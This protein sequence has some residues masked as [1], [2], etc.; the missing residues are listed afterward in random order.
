MKHFLILGSRIALGVY[1]PALSL[2]K[3]LEALGDQADLFCLEELY[4]GKDRVMEATKRSMHDD[5][6]LAR[7]S[8]RM[9]VRN[10]SV[11]DP[12]AE[13]AFVKNAAEKQY[14]A[15]IAFSGFFTAFLNCLCRESSHYQGRIY[16]VHMDAGVSRSWRDA[17]LSGIQEIWLYQLAGQKIH[18]SLEK[19]TEPTE[20]LPRMLVHGGGWGIGV[21]RDQIRSLNERGIPLD[22]IVYYPEEAEQIDPMNACFLLD[23]AWKPSAG[24][25]E[26][27]RLL[28]QDADGW[29]PFAD[30]RHRNPVRTLMEQDIAVLSKPGGGTLADSLCTG[31]PLIFSEAL[32]SYETEN[33]TLWEQCGFGIGFEDF[34]KTSDWNETLMEQRNR[35]L[36]TA[37][38]LP[39]LADC[40]HPSSEEGGRIHA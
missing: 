26:Y 9:P 25:A 6:R 32:A 18:R 28:K 19:R 2:K 38:H 29:N 36:E 14:D 8:Y 11:I 10:Q 17:D 30:S 15:V 23:P 22:V 4:Q 21:Y 24:H 31:T 37:E 35:L 16:A 12:A 13:T 34:Q 33:R 40:F 39:V 1:V 20:K 27:P 7:I 5:F 3:Q